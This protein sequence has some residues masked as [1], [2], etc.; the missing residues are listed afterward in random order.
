[1]FLLRPKAARKPYSYIGYDEATDTGY[2]VDSMSRDGRAF[3]DFSDS[4]FDDV[5]G[6]G[7][8]FMRYL[9]NYIHSDSEV[10]VDDLSVPE[11][12]YS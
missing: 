1:V 11:R 8:A 2:Y 12:H 4:G 7:I 10:N 6:F 3:E 5:I 9:I